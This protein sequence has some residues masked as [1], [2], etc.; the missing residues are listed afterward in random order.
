MEDNSEFCEQIGKAVVELG[1]AEAL[2]CMARMMAVVAQN[3][4]KDIEFDCDLAVISVERK[5][6]KLNS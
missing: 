6:I 4:G 5:T 2:A 1:T 3:E